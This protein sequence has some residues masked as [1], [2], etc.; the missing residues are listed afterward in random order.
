MTVIRVRE[1]GMYLC[2]G[3]EERGCS[4]ESDTV[5][6]A[7]F[8]YL[9]K[10]CM[11]CC[12]YI[13]CWLVIPRDGRSANDQRAIIGFK[14]HGASVLYSSSVETDFDLDGINYRIH[15]TVKLIVPIVCHLLYL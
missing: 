12:T 10:N 11:Y 6:C 9:N 5:S 1:S 15:S 8:I 13:D 4:D 7:A 3:Y 2:G 14:F